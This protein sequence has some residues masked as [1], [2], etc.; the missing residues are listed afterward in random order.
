MED[1][2]VNKDDWWKYP[3]SFLKVIMNTGETQQVTRHDIN[4]EILESLIPGWERQRRCPD[5]PYVTY[6]EV[7]RFANHVIHAA[8]SDVPGFG[9]DSHCY[10]Y[11]ASQYE[12]LHDW[13][14]ELAEHDYLELTDRSGMQWH[15]P[16]KPESKPFLAVIRLTDGQLT[17]AHAAMPGPDWLADV[18]SAIGFLLM[19]TFSKWGSCL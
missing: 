6:I 3:D 11:F 19:K 15:M 14:W 8:W 5:D 4:S 1:W 12:N 2:R 9:I 7:P 13:T 16:E 17:A 10:G 18:E